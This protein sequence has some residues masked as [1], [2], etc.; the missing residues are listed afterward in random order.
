MRKGS[1]PKSQV[2]LAA[3]ASNWDTINP[4]RDPPPPPLP[5]VKGSKKKGL[6][7]R[8]HSCPVLPMPAQDAGQVTHPRDTHRQEARV[9]HQDVGAFADQVPQVPGKILLKVLQLLRDR[10]RGSEP[11]LP[12]SSCLPHPST[13]CPKSQKQS[14]PP[15]HPVY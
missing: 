8:E 14:L 5:N 10:A 11:G 13:S 4:E 9:P 12:D 7:G 3:S 6:Q 2:L 1:P 15:P